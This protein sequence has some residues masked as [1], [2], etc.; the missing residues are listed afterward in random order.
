[1]GALAEQLA[2]DA[3]TQRAADQT[4]DLQRAT[5]LL[6][7]CGLAIVAGVGR[8]RQHA[9]LGGNPAFALAAQEAGHAVLDTGGAQHPG[10]AEADQHRALGVAG[11]PA[12]DPYLAQLVG[13]AAA[14]AGELGRAG[15][16]H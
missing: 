3:R 13:G 7:A 12:L 1:D 10:V 9:V 15:N 8:A 6:A 4:L 14:G 11:E 16:W 2:V 5:A